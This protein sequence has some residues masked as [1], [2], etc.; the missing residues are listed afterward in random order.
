MMEEKVRDS[1]ERDEDLLYVMIDIGVEQTL[2]KLYRIW[3][4]NAIT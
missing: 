2:N 4:Y 3:N 1:K